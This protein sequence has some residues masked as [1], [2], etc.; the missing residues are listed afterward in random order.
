MVLS[1][2]F[3]SSLSISWFESTRV[4]IVSLSVCVWERFVGGR[5]SSLPVAWALWLGMANFWCT[6]SSSQ[7]PD[8]MFC[9][10]AHWNLNNG[11]SFQPTPP[12]ELLRIDS[13][14]CKH[15]GTQFEVL[16]F[17]SLGMEWIVGFG[18]ELES[19]EK[20]VAESLDGRT[21]TRQCAFSVRKQLKFALTGWSEASL[22]RMK[23]C[24]VDRSESVRRP[25]FC[26]FWWRIDKHLSYHVSNLLVHVNSLG[27]SSRRRLQARSLLLTLLLASAAL[28]GNPS[29]LTF[30]VQENVEA[31][32]YNSSPFSRIGDGWY[33]DACW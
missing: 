7:F 32:D 4:S 20:V 3:L 11:A 21:T 16:Y 19:I 17:E 2:L 18:S 8:L 24:W 28:S 5:W 31:R 6:I 9:E 27:Q 1:L 23:R 33:Q 22:L 15:G 12:W 25:K 14:F 26:V 29:P 30:G 10:V 13:I